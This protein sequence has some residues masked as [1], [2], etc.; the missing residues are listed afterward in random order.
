MLSSVLNSNRAIQVNIAIMRTFVQLRNLMA[1]NRL[2]A[3]R[4]GELESRYDQQFQAIAEAIQQLIDA[5]QSRTKS[6][7]SVGF[8]QHL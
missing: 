8:H 2:L 6:K 5:D 1:S 3:D 7:Q 4:I